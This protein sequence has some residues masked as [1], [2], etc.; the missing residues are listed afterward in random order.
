MDKVLEPKEQS[1]DKND[2]EE[3]GFVKLQKIISPFLFWKDKLQCFKWQETAFSLKTFVSDC[4]K[5]KTYSE[6]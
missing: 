5:N 6:H 1:A 4:W 2:S 3:Q